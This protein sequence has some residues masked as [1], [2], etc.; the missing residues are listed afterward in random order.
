MLTPPSLSSHV[1]DRAFRAANGELGIR[2]EDID[3]FLAACERDKVAIFGCEA[4]LVNHR[5]AFEGD[6]I[7]ALGQWCGMIP[8]KGSDDPM[9]FS[10]GVDGPESNEPWSE[11]VRR[12]ISEVRAELS[13]FDP[14]SELPQKWLPHFRIN[15][16]I[17]L[18]H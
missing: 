8:M 12:S 10:F 16:T 14:E 9:V 18:E 7:P 5:A 15:F 17:G 2:R 1:V 13:G 6:P 11:F 3:V 4:W